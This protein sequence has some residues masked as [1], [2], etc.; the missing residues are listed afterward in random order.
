MTKTTQNY[1]GAFFDL[2]L[3]Y[4]VEIKKAWL[5]VIIES[6]NSIDSKSTI[7]VLI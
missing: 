4:R 2:K 7:P 5:V 6:I 1:F 3:L